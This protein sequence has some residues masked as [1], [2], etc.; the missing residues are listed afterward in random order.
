M[1]A[2]RTDIAPRGPVSFPDTGLGTGWERPALTAITLVLLSFGLVN[3]YS[4]S[5]FLAQRQGLP[6]S[7]YV[8]RQTG[9]AALGLVLLVACARVPYRWWR[10]LAWPI[11]LIT[12][13][14][15][16]ALVLPWT[17]GIAPEIN[18]ARRWIH[19]LGMSF[20]P[21]ELAK[22]AIVVWTAHLAVKKQDEFRSLSRG[23][24]PFL[25]M[26]TV[27]LVPILLQP[28]LSTAFIVGMAGAI[29][30]FVA[31]ARVGHFV[32][33]GLLLTPVALSQLGSGFRPDRW[34]SFLNLDAYVSS[35]GYQVNQ[36][37]IALGSG[38]ITGVG[39][40]EGRQKFGFLP[41]PH[42][43][44]IFSMIGE[45]W[46]LLGVGFLIG[47]YMSV[48][49]I[50]FR[51]ARRA[52]DRFGQ[53]LAIGIASL[54]APTCS[55][56]YGGG[57]R[58]RPPDGTLA[59]PR[60]VRT[61]ESPRDAN[62]HRDLTVS[63]SGYRPHRGAGLM[64]EPVVAVFSGGGTG[65]HLYPALAL[66]AAL[67][68]R[69]PDVHPFFVGAER[70]LEARILPE[71]GLDHLLVPIEGIRR[72]SLLMNMRVVGLLVG[73]IRQVTDAFQR[74]RPHLVVVTGGYAGGPAGLAAVLTR[75][76]LV[77]QEQNSLPGL[78]TRFLS[79]FARE[80]HLAFPEAVA[81][82]P[83]WTRSKAK[84]SGNPVQPPVRQDRSIAAEAFGL[85]PDGTTLLVVGGSQGSRAVNEVV[86]EAVRKV[87][88]GSFER[89]SGLQI[90]WA[91]GPAH[92]E[93]IEGSSKQPDGPSGSGSWVTS[94]TC[95]SPSRW[96]S[97]PSA[98][99]GRW[100]PPSSW[101][102]AS[103]RSTSPY[104]LPP[105]DHQARN[106]RALCDAGVALHLPKRR[107]RGRFYGRQS[108]DSSVTRKLVPGCRKRQG[109][110]VA[111][112]LRAK[113]Q[114]PW[115]GCSHLPVRRHG[116]EARAA[117]REHWPH[118]AGRFP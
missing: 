54:V 102:G 103:R 118:S 62:G 97:W 21:S 24:L 77:L 65:G 22:I 101:P 109:N 41:E 57:T 117:N 76:R 94:M 90:L 1:S 74:L 36:S 45:E 5:A 37:L 56:S 93:G 2:L 30:L 100:R 59:S 18:G 73:A 25:I 71:R 87:M 66:A 43:D 96:R 98:V 89:P 32:F 85:D 110:G 47:L 23:M 7:F 111:P 75:T 80:V 35:A 46:G 51:I 4:A 70:G 34:R 114:P 78:T 91:T 31:G 64:T 3:L 116:Y 8:L 49:L 105:E 29:T 69:R 67:A 113:L 81:A 53:L 15:L 108:T 99:P 63:G 27:L 12:A 52:P 88:K 28:D 50:G 11:L 115:T 61:V 106:A 84:V 107:C 58:A 86:L 9:G 20:Q 19:L 16:L 72:D 10:V 13:L 48:V 44:F 26:W 39:F 14:V 83:R 55:A 104:P 17:T 68:E 42:N 79:L 95:L 60:I 112:W 6:D 38:G 40:G 92:L 82:L 33:L